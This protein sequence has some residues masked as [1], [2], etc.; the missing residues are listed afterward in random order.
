M[1]RLF[2][3]SVVLGISTGVVGVGDLSAGEVDHAARYRACMAM[4]D[5]DPKMAFT[6][7]IRWRDLGGGEG[8]DHCAAAALIGLAQYREAA[9]RLEELALDS[10]RAP[11][12]KA[13]ILAQASQ[14]WLLSGDATRAE[15]VATAALT[16]APEDPDILIDRAQARAQLKDYQGAL[17]DLNAS[18]RIYPSDADA[19]VFRATA[20]RYLGDISNAAVD[21]QVALQINQSHAEALLERGILRRLSNNNEGARKD[22]LIVLSIAPHS[23]AAKAAKLNLEKMDVMPD[24]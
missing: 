13:G 4:V 16:M 5:K 19:L 24:Q 23:D 9:A 20:K 11:E 10:R 18:L 8:A 12:M 7:A 2:F 15:A 17:D 22:W 6:D 1:F 3:I 21:I 14:A